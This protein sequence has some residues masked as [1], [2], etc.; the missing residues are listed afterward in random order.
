MI[1]VRIGDHKHI[2]RK[3]RQKVVEKRMCKKIAENPSKIVKERNSSYSYI[4]KAAKWR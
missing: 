1:E 2:A 4:E 3:F